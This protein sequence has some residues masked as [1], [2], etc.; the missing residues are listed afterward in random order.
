MKTLK[1]LGA[2]LAAVTMTFTAQAE[3]TAKAVLTDS[4]ATLKFVYD[5]ADYGT[6][7]TDWFS[8]AEA[9]ALDP[10]FS[11]EWGSC[12][13]TVTKV[14]FDPSFADYRPVRCNRWFDGFSRLETIEGSGNLD[15]SKADNLSSMFSDCRS[16]ETL[17]LTSFDT[18]RVTSC[19]GMFN[20]C[21]NLKTIYATYLFDI[22]GKVNSSTVMFS[23]CTALKGGAG[24]T[25]SDSKKDATC[26]RIDGGVSEVG[27]FTRGKLAR[28]EVCDEGATLRFY[29][30]NKDLSGLT[31]GTDWFSVAEAET[32]ISL[33]DDV[34][35]HG[36]AGTVTKVVF[37]SSFAD[38]KPKKCKSWFL[39]FKAL[40]T[41][42][43]IGYLDTSSATSFASMF[44]GCSKLT[45]LDLTGFDTS[46]VTCMIQ[47]FFD[48]RSLTSL[49]VT[50]FDTSKV[51]DMDCMFCN[52]TSLKSLDVTGFDTSK[53]TDMALMFCYCSSLKSLDL[54]GFDTSKVTSM[55]AMFSGCSSLKSIY[56]SDAFVTTEVGNSQGM[57][58]DCTLLKGGAGTSY[59]SFNPLD[60]TYARIDG[61][62]MSDAP[63]Y[64][65]RGYSAQVGEYG[66]WTLADF[67]IEPPAAGTVYSVKAYGLPS[68]LKLKYNAAQKDKKGKVI[69]KAKTDWWIEGVP[70]SALN[71][72]E[73][74]MYLAVTVGGKTT[75][76]PVPLLVKAQSV[77]DMGTFTVGTALTQT[78]WLPGLAGGGWSVSG[79][80]KGLKY[81][82]NI[83]Y[84]DPKKKS[85]G[86]KYDADTTYG[87]FSAAGLYTV[88]AKKKAGSFYETLKFKMLVNPAGEFT[89]R[90]FTAYETFATMKDTS[91]KAVSGLPAGLKFTA[92]KY[93]VS[94]K[95]TKAGTFA[96][97][98]T[99]KKGKAWTEMWIVAA[100]PDGP[101]LGF[102]TT[103]ETSMSVLQGQTGEG[104]ALTFPADGT[105]SV[106][107]LPK[108]MKL[109]KNADGTYALG[110]VPSVTGTFF[111]TV[112]AVKNGRT[113]TQR[114]AVT[115]KA[116]PFA[117][118]YRG[119]VCYVGGNLWRTIS[120]SI[121][122]SGKATLKYME[123]SA[124]YTLTASAGKPL[125]NGSGAVNKYFYT[126]VQKANTKKKLPARTV[127]ARHDV[128]G[129]KAYVYNDADGWRDG[130]AADAFAAVGDIDQTLPLAKINVFKASGQ[131]VFAAKATFVSEGRTDAGQ[132]LYATTAYDAEKGTFAVKG[133]LPLGKAFSATVPLNWL[134]NFC[135]APFSAADADGTRYVIT[136]N[137]DAKNPGFLFDIPSQVAADGD[138]RDSLDTTSRFMPFVVNAFGT[139]YT[140]L[141]TTF[142]AAVKNTAADYI[143]VTVTYPAKGT[144]LVNEK[145]EFLLRATSTKYFQVSFD[146]GATWT[147]KAD[148]K[149]DKKRGFASI[150][151]TKGKSK[152]TV[153]LL[154]I[155]PERLEGQ[156]KRQSNPKYDKKTKKTT[157]TTEYGKVLAEPAT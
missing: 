48:C 24:T 23:G 19:N 99:P 137:P 150:S 148:A 74:P 41:I 49:D 153:D 89:T 42:E 116:N 56:A 75:W 60:K 71:A 141:P 155:E 66:K 33:A 101:E 124:T 28:V 1:I 103:G 2:A 82:A 147:T 45:S 83:V 80:P 15:I 91:W 55:E 9:E 96:V 34:P 110:G 111:V 136:L 37:T 132:T 53:V 98:F 18:K 144:P 131:L 52:C 113:V 54:T 46:K 121:A 86:I 14:I 127:I 26:A 107:G 5:E 102:N 58:K 92:K 35:W 94:G 36:C 47:T 21:S 6:K 38:Y 139:G 22:S 149:Y 30:D 12:W 78:G 27:Y 122:A 114:V 31:R 95:I 29:Y 119:S 16:L 62:R 88:T 133:K 100:N 118:S 85:K 93:T 115:V 126:F 120:L 59:D 67:G 145:E 104:N 57:F 10:S 81:T 73:R 129:F 44:S 117:G 20:G 109:V 128:I 146:G 123:K 152:Y 25:Y 156:V 130:A 68:G 13:K 79:L 76:H 64:F 108:G 3:K 138:S 69:V 140:A 125:L 97:T 72:Q 112:K 135:L 40:A 70:T 4:G 8:V 77:T 61:G 143:P 87:K 50:G 154:Y 17:D 151:F 11:P 43:N 65:T 90:N 7:G 63:G 39:R 106:S 142:A 84:K 32:V 134:I 157:Y 105:V 51:T